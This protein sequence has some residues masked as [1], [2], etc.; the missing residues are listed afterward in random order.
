MRKRCPTTGFETIAFLQAFL[1]LVFRRMSIQ[2][3]T[4]NLPVPQVDDS[5][6][7]CDFVAILV[8]FIVS[9][10]VDSSKQ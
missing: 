1:L 4:P 9:S 10:V 2:T 3:V 5:G 6:V 8:V 7:S